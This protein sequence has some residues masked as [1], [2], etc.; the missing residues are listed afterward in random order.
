M[1]AT[2]IFEKVVSDFPEKHGTEQKN[3]RGVYIDRVRSAGIQIRTSCF[4]KNY[5]F[6]C[7]WHILCDISAGTGCVKLALMFE[8]DH[9]LLL[10]Q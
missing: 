7:H 8:T 5:S 10:N 2:D 1:T 4:D 3:L 6:N 9:V